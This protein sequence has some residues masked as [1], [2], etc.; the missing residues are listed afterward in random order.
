VPGEFAKPPPRHSRAEQGLGLPVLVD[1]F[2][3]LPAS[4]GVV[5]P[6]ALDRVCGAPM[7]GKVLRA[8]H[9]ELSRLLADCGIGGM[10]GLKDIKG[11]EGTQGST[12]L[13][14]QE[15]QVGGLAFDQ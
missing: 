9:D 2:R 3:S 4:A 1:H 13:A 5:T 14:L 6:L 15:C 7:R 11:L 12:G 8:A 10:S